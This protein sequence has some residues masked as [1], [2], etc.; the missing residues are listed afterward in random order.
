MADLRQEYR[1]GRGTV[2]LLVGLIPHVRVGRRVLVRREDVE[3][4]LERAAAGGMDIRAMA[5]AVKRGESR[6]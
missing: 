6:R 4:F 5:K 3:A 2:Y 1:L